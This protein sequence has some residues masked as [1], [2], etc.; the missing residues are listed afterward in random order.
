MSRGLPRLSLVSLFALT[1][2]GAAAAHAVPVKY[3]FS[4][5][6]N[7]T[8]WRTGATGLDEELVTRLSGLSVS[9]TFM[10]DSAVPQTG[11]RDD[12]AVSG[13][14]IYDGA[15]SQLAGSLGSFQFTASTGIGQVANEGS[16]AGPTPASPRNIFD[17]FGLY[18]YAD[19]EQTMAGIDR[20]FTGAGLTWQETAFPFRPDFLTSNALLDTFPGIDAYLV[21]NF[22]SS[23]SPYTSIAIFDDLTITRVEE[24]P[25]PG[26]LSLMALAGATLFFG[27]RRRRKALAK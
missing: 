27:I 12:A 13:M 11:F 23:T 2:L 25:E 19:G 7:F 8:V 26:T 6:P 24:V 9:G 18:A 4:T 20:T 5:G 17:V 3:Q 15:I 1:A 22:T 16:F 14:S 21:M 10:Y